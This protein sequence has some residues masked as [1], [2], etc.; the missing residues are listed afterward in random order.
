M[1]AIGPTFDE[2]LEEVD[3]QKRLIDSI[4]AGE[5]HTGCSNPSTSTS[6]STRSFIHHPKPGMN[7]PDVPDKELRWKLLQYYLDWVHPQLPF[8]DI[9]Q[10]MEMIMAEDFAKTKDILIVL[11]Q[12]IFY[13]GSLYAQEEDFQSGCYLSKRHAQESLA[14]NAKVCF[15]S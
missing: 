8:L 13:A 10:V 9:Q 15:E 4:T 5:K 6:E 2:T 7:L 14:N 3:A 1:S 11:V 12:A